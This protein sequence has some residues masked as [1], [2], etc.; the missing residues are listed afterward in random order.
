MMETAASSAESASDILPSPAQI[1]AQKLFEDHPPGQLNEVNRAGYLALEEGDLRLAQAAAD[2]VITRAT[3]KSG[4]LLR[5]QVL[6]ALIYEKQGDTQK[7]S[8]LMED[9]IKGRF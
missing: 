1:Y 6:R 8:C 4:D 3:E 2:F 7:F 5:G 9:V